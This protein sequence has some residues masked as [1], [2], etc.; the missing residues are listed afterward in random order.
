MPATLT[1]RFTSPADLVAAAR[2]SK[3]THWFDRDSMRFFGSRL[4]RTVYGPGGRV[5]TTSETNPSGV[6]RYSVRVLQ[7]DA[8]NRYTVDTVGAFGALTTSPQAATAAARVGRA[9]HDAGVEGDYLDDDTLAVL[10][11]QAKVPT[12]GFMDL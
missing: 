5:F 7:V 8:G 2:A 3:T 6:T 10:A 12:T 1:L 11:E 4:G 9:L